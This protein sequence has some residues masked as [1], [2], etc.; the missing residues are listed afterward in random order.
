MG[1]V[2]RGAWYAAINAAV[3][4]AVAVVFNYNRFIVL[5]GGGKSLA[6]IAISF[7]ILL[8]VVAG[9]FYLTEHDYSQ[10]RR[11]QVVHIALLVLAVAAAAIVGVS[12]IHFSMKLV[13]IVIFG[14]IA[15]AVG[16]LEAWIAEK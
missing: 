7:V 14:L 16:A 15:V 11:S 10:H 6:A 1:Y 3:M 8:V 12:W 9:G 5:L 4:V 2:T 13:G